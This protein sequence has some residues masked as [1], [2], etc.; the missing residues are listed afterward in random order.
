MRDKLLVVGHARHGKDTVCEIL[1][2]NW[3]YTFISSSYFCAEKVIMAE[4]PGRWLSVEECYADRVNHRALWYDLIAATNTPD[5][6]NLAR[7]IYE[8]GYDIYCGMRNKRELHAARNSGLVDLIVWVDASDRLPLED[9]SSCTI[10][11]W[12]ADVTIDNNGSE[13][14]LEFNVNQLAKFLEESNNAD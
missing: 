8:S 5:G 14:D 11:Q 7:Q 6:A 13:A 12:M 3:G 4:Y 1:Q 2:R 10:E 9:K